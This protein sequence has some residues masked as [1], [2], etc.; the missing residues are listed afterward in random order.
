M[1]FLWLLLFPLITFGVDISYRKVQCEAYLMGTLQ[2]KTIFYLFPG[3]SESSRL[4]LNRGE[5]EIFL[6]IDHNIIQNSKISV[7]DYHWGTKSK[8]DVKIKVEKEFKMKDLETSIL[9]IQIP[10]KN[11]SKTATIRCQILPKM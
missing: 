10:T 5:D 7:K 1:R 3:K 9:E 11:S 2:D 4:S 6:S 8:P